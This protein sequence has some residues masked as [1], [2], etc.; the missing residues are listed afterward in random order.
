LDERLLVVFPP[1]HGDVFGV[2][3][4]FPGC[5]AFRADQA[6]AFAN[7]IVDDLVSNKAAH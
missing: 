6:E 2:A 4:A 7:E 3:L 1:E 5:E